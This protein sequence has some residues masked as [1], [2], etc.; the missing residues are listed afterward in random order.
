MRHA[1]EYINGEIIRIR[2]NASVSIDLAL[3]YTAQL[4]GVAE[5]A[6][7]TLLNKG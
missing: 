7:R 4:N 6:N 3:P 2:A 5:R 1:K